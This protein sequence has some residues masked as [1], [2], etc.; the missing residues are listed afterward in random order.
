MHLRLLHGMLSEVEVLVYSVGRG[1]IVLQRAPRSWP[2]S[3]DNFRMISQW[4]TTFVLACQME[5]VR[6]SQYLEYENCSMRANYALLKHTRPVL[7]GEE[8]RNSGPFLSKKRVSILKSFQWIVN[9]PIGKNHRAQS[10][11]TGEQ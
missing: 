11:K 5:P 3:L 10:R 8:P 9:S 7:R 6:N 2:S 1:A 4:G